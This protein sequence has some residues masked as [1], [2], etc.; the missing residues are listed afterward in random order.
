[1]AM[2]E[3]RSVP[4]SCPACRGAVGRE[5]ESYFCARCQ[6][7]YPICYGIPDFR[8]E[9][10]PYISFEEEQEKAGKIAQA[11]ATT[12]FE[13]LV[14]YYWEITPE[15]PADAVERFVHYALD[16]VS[17]GAFVVSEMDRL[18]GGRW[19]GRTCLDIGCGT[20]GFLVAAR[21]RFDHV[22]GCDIALRWLVIAKKR[23]SETEQSATLVCCSADRLPFAEGVFDGVVGFHV[24]EHARFPQGVLAE[25]ART[26]R[27]GG[28]FYFATP[29]RFSLGPEPSVRVWGVGFLPVRWRHAYVRLV[30]GI[31]Y[32]HITLLSW[33]GL[34]KG[35]SQLD[36]KKAAV[37]PQRIGR[38]EQNR[39]GPV[40]RKTIAFYNRLCRLPISRTLLRLFGPFLQVFG[41]K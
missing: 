21:S 25:T 29:N 13:G 12:D 35:L 36:L 17:R 33:F 41:E 14:R 22:I 16:G 23:L 4:F 31:R 39:V 3:P 24:L 26:L 7:R 34:R 40:L 15:T 8:L 30:K 5:D 9:P 11:A 20:G 1:M 19:Q 32:D 2:T 18:T 28:H 38:A 6:R 37:Q 27:A 10:D